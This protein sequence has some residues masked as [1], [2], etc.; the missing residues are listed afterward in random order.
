MAEVF[1]GCS[2]GFHQIVEHLHG[3][4]LI[5]QPSSMILLDVSQLDLVFD[6]VKSDGHRADDPHEVEPVGDEHVVAVSVLIQLLL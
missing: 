3:Q 6:L 4:V 5:V 1:V 2:T